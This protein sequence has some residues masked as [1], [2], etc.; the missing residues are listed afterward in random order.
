MQAIPSGGRGDIV[1]IQH[2]QWEDEDEY[3]CVCYGCV[4]EGVVTWPSIE[5]TQAQV[6]LVTT[7][8][9]FSWLGLGKAQ[10]K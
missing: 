7:Q 3:D 10:G 8:E 6:P 5:R 1:Y 4:C 9:S 2:R